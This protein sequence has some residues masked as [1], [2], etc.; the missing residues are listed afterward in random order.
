[1][2]D[3]T[4]EICMRAWNRLAVVALVAFGPS[5]CLSGSVKQ[6]LVAYGTAASGLASTGEVLV[7]RC[8]TETNPD[9][10]KAACD[11]A[12]ESFKS[13]GSSAGQLKKVGE[14]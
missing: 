2:S 1:V 8:E 14:N 7:A 12:R 3:S 11:A 4:K 10:K 9:A 13:I 6:A 5:A